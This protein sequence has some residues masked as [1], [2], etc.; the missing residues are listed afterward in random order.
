MGFIRYHEKKEDHFSEVL[1]YSHAQQEEDRKEKEERFAA[2][3]LSNK[4]GEAIR[5]LPPNQAMKQFALIYRRLSDI[6]IQISENEPC[7]NSTQKEQLWKDFIVDIC[8]RMMLLFYQDQTERCN[9]IQTMV[10][11]VFRLTDIR[12]SDHFHLLHDSKRYR[13][14]FDRCFFPE[15]KDSLQF[16]RFLSFSDKRPTKAATQEFM[17]CLK[18]F[19]GLFIYFL[20]KITG[21]ESQFWTTQADDLIRQIEEV[22]EIFRR[23]PAPE[24]RKLI[25]PIYGSENPSRENIFNWYRVVLFGKLPN[26]DNRNSM[27]EDLYESF[28]IEELKKIRLDSI[29]PEAFKSKIQSGILPEFCRED[30]EEEKKINYLDH[31]I[32]YHKATGS[33]QEAPF[34]AVKGRV[35]L[36]DNALLF[37][38]WENH[39]ISYESL[40]KAVLY[41][42]VPDIV[43]VE[44]EDSLLYFQVPDAELF[45]QVLRIVARKTET[46]M[47][48]A[49]N[50]GYSYTKLLSDSGIPSCI[51]AL[52]SISEDD[53]PVEMK[54]EI[55]KIL[56]AI[57]KCR[58][59]KGGNAHGN[60]ELETFVAI[61]LPDVINLL[62]SY[63]AYEK[64][65]V[66]QKMTDQV[67]RKTE[68]TV[69]EF[70]GTLIR[71]IYDIYS[72]QAVS[73]ITEAETL[74]TVFENETTTEEKLPFTYEELVEK[75]DLDQCIGAM[76]YVSSYMLPDELN[77]M[78]LSIIGR[79]KGLKRTLE[80]Y[81]GRKDEVQSFLGY[82]VPEAVRIIVSYDRYTKAGLDDSTI[83][84]VYNKV[85]DSVSMLDEALAN[86]IT[87]IT[88]MET[89]KTVAQAEALAQIMSQDGFIKKGNLLI[90]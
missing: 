16:Y 74:I 31:C 38:G 9:A 30:F 15:R 29:L 50:D 27:I 71:K 62:H 33:N 75:S 88:R 64:Q 3:W 58:D 1:D 44:D 79:L 47:P 90:H 63:L 65:D 67:Y 11:K 57:R 13:Y 52:E 24:P 42:A 8:D 4:N 83:K 40:K 2:E 23:L 55:S 17:V 45:Y 61:Y 89:M 81:P 68:E 85:L 56:R 37:K 34:T 77:S 7:L 12:I 84:K 69:R 66:D 53:V 49:S 39:S 22:T 19:S 48:E 36:T 32:L 54:E 59:V 78:I 80:L 46:M 43:E 51:F 28:E 25:N 86:K 72:E 70:H 87:D 6:W 14:Y 20:F 60:D 76:V 18:K 21:R 5:P 26:G 41:D 73:I 35:Y 10:S 82:Y